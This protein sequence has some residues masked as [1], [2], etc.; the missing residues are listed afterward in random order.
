MARDGFR[1]AGYE[2]IVIDDCWSELE[3]DSQTGALVPDLKRFPSG[4]KHLGDYVILIQFIFN[5]FIKIY[6]KSPYLYRFTRWDWNS[7]ST[8]TMELKRVLVIRALLATKRLMRNR[9]LIGVSTMWSWMVA[10]RILIRWMKV[11]SR[12]VLSR[13]DLVIAIFLHLGYPNFGALLNQTGRPMVY[14]C[15]WPVYQEVNGIMVG[16][17]TISNYMVLINKIIYF[18]PTSSWSPSTAICGATGT[19]STI[20]GIRW[21][22]LSSTLPRI[23]IES[24]RMRHPVTGTIRT[25]C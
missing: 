9:L 21:K 11:K 8:R 23:K 17:K 14:S 12:M 4:L 22:R 3:R 13:I 6:I 5:T 19:T 24:L 25:C 2:Y 7:V 15:S 20:P 10:I 1:E 18:S 16:L